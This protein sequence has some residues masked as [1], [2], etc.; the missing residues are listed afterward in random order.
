MYLTI[1]IRTNVLCAA[2]GTTL[3]PIGTGLTALSSSSNSGISASAKTAAIIVPIVVALILLTICIVCI[4]TG[5]SFSLGSGMVKKQS[6]SS[7]TKEVTGTGPYAQQPEASQVSA[8]ESHNDVELSQV[9][10]ASTANEV[11]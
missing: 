8:A 1:T 2:P 5:C 4:I 7:G 3:T 11:A 10:E 6:S 9:G